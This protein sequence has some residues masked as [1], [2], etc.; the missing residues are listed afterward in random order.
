V[1]TNLHPA[2]ADSPRAR[3][4]Q[5]IV[6]NCVHC[7]FCNATCPTYLELGDERDGPRGRIYLI[8]Q[9]L[10]TGDVTE[11]SRRHLDRCLTCRAC[12]TTC[13]SGV[14]YGRLADY[15]REVMERRTTR[16]P[17]SRVQR[18]ALRLIVPHRRR[19]ALLLKLGQWVRP[20]MPRRLRE[21]I[22]ERQPRAPLP[23]AGHRRRVVLLDGCAQSAATP[24]TND[25]ARRVLDRLGITAVTLPRVGCCGAVSYHLSQHDEARRFVRR[26]TDDL[27]QEVGAAAAQAAKPIDDLRASAEYRRHLVNVLTQRALRKAWASAKAKKGA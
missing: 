18:R 12:E 6:A 19:F 14:E 8:R 2:F 25:A 16:K 15:G 5:A 27:L 4:A 24:R 23:A 3:R 20:L 1:H 21:R 22:P 11:N 9:L 13:P 26:N 10:E 17:L 7:G